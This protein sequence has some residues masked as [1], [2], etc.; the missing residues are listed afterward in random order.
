MVRSPR[1]TRRLGAVLL[2]AALGAGAL[3][4]LPAGAAETPTSR[5]TTR[6]ALIGTTTSCPH[7]ETTLFTGATGLVPRD[8][9]HMTP[10]GTPPPGGWPA[11]IMWSPSFWG[12]EVAWSANTILP[13][14]AYYDTMQIKALLDNGFVVITPESHLEGFTFWDTNN[15]LTPNW[16]T[17]PDKYF[18]DDILAAVRRGR[19]GAVDPGRLFTTG[20]SSGGYM[21][22]RMAI[23]Y[24]GVFRAVAIQSGSYATCLGPLCSVPATMPTTHAPTLFL[25]G[26]ADLIVPLSTMVPYRD[27]L[28]AAGVPTRTVTKAGAG[29]EFLPGSPVELVAWFAAHDPGR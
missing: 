24:P 29:H 28:D 17:A 10:L 4:A 5:C 13:A 25:H 16:D 18:T 3:G 15:P 8:V 7:H 9:H 21:T 23:G 22:S 2:V 19:F 27:R 6:K 26:T 12:A 14:G 1:A 11:V 20:M